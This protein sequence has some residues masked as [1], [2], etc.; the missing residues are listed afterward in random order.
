[1]AWWVNTGAKLHPP[2]IVLLVDFPHTLVP[3]C[4]TSALLLPSWLGWLTA[5]FLPQSPSGWGETVRICSVRVGVGSVPC[6]ASIA[7]LPMSGLP[8]SDLCLLSVDIKWVENITSWYK[9]QF[10]WGLWFAAPLRTTAV[11][12]H[13]CLCILRWSQWLRT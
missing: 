3:I 11:D 8:G 12:Y 1:M 6:D 7:R 4:R 10:M 13:W 5:Q 2:H 9:S